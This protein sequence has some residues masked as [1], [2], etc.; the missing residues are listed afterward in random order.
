VSRITNQ[1]LPLARLVDAAPSEGAGALWPVDRGETRTGRHLE[2]NRLDSCTTS[3]PL[4]GRLKFLDRFAHQAL[5]AGTALISRPISSG[6]SSRGPIDAPPPTRASRSLM[7]PWREGGTARARAGWPSPGIPPNGMLMP[8]SG[9]CRRRAP[10][11]AQ[12]GR[13]SS[14]SGSTLPISTGLSLSILVARLRLCADCR[15]ESGCLSGRP[16]GPS[17]V[18]AS[19]RFPDL[20]ALRREKDDQHDARVGRDSGVQWREIP[21]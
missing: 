3:T 19:V 6:S 2:W 16:A 15:A 4:A 7:S 5:K 9:Q 8:Q 10:R 21:C 12:G 18:H 13:E 1:A 17:R 11:R 14:S 20:G